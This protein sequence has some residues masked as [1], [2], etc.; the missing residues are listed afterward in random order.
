MTSA[1]ND[2]LDDL[3]PQQLRQLLFDHWTRSRGVT[4]ASIKAWRR[5]RGLS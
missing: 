5:A 2:L 3:D 4:R 1:L